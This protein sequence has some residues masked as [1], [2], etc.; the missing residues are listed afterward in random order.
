MK[1]LFLALTTTA[2]LASAGATLAAGPGHGPGQ[3]HRGAHMGR[4]LDSINATDA[5]REQIKAIMQS[6]KE[7]A[8]AD[9]KQIAATRRALHE[10]DPMASSYSSEVARLADELAQ[11]TR[12]ATIDKANIRAQVAA[13]LT[14]EQRATLAQ[15]RAEREQ[16]QA[17]RRERMKARRAERNDS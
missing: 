2:L 17:E 11:A 3:M 8:K 16:R 1:K 9:W 7:Q 6:N 15:Q 5:Q 13:V 4:M 14:S 10:L 12:Q